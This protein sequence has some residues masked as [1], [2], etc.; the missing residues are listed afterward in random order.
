[1]NVSALRT[2]LKARN[3][4]S[5]G[6]KSQLVARLT[7][8]LKMEAEKTEDSSKD[9][10]PEPETEVIEEKKAEVSVVILVC[11][12]WDKRIDKKLLISLHWEVSPDS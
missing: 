5:K 7:K 6:L 4:N 3:I 10:Q 2:E 12:Q 11:I 8:A 1:M 9:G